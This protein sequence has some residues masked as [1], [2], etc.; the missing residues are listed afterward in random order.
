MNELKCSHLHCGRIAAWFDE[1]RYEVRLPLCNG[2]KTATSKPYEPI[3]LIDAGELRSVV[4]MPREWN[5]PCGHRQV[6]VDEE[7]QTVR[8]E[9]CG[10]S[11]NPVACLMEIAKE[12]R[13]VDYKI[14]A[15][16]ELS[17]KENE[18]RQRR[19][20]REI[21]REAKRIGISAKD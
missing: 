8:C 13:S 14:N 15:V 21:N 12:L 3:E 18:A 2:H 20:I 5:P 6:I 19:R 9:A 17:R 1:V 4:I 7:S 16:A 11:I 10:K